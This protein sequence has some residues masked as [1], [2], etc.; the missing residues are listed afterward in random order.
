MY[1]ALADQKTYIKNSGVK[2]IGC[3]VPMWEHQTKIWFNHFISHATND[4]GG[5]G[6]RYGMTNSDTLRKDCYFFL[7]KH[8]VKN[9]P[10]YDR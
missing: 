8:G 7:K 1:T 9:I 10:K 4:R 2:N 5:V 6:K 3:D